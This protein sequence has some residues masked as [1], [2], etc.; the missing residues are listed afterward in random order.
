VTD[1]DE[2]VIAADFR[3]SANLKPWSGAQVWGLGSFVTQQIAGADRVVV[4]IGSSSLTGVD[5]ALD[6]QRLDFIVEVLAERVR[7]GQQVVLVTS[8]AVAAG[9][10]PMGLT[11]RPKH[12]PTQQAAA[13]VG[14]GLLL[15]HY[16]EQFRIRGIT[17]GQV[18]LT[19][20]DLTRRSHYSNA[21]HTLECLLS[22]DV[23]YRHENDCRDPHSW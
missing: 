12:L 16:T 7:L 18:L 10:V 21:K 15:A 3:G 23:F 9:I 19:S 6:Y 13:S 17:V 1:A 2:L 4:K 22:F 5:G 8:G 11:V 20:A 14:Q